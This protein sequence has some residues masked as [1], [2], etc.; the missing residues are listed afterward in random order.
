MTSG[1]LCNRLCYYDE[2]DIADFYTS[3]KYVML[4]NFGGQKMVLKS[5]HSQFSHFDSLEANLT[6]SAFEDLVLNVVN[7]NLHV[8]WPSVYKK[9]LIELVWPPSTRTTTMSAADRRSL[10]S[11]LQQ[12]GYEQYMYHY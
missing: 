7:R 12:V 4:I 9:N 2:W 1:D 3:N 11:L 6:Q 10:W 5:L 8:G